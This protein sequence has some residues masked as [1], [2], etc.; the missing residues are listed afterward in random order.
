MARTRSSVFVCL[1]LL[2]GFSVPPVQADEIILN[3]GDRIHGTIVKMAD[4]LLTVTTPYADELKLNWKDVR[5]IVADRP[6]QVELN[7]ED[8]PITLSDFFFLEPP[9]VP[10][11]R[12]GEGSEIP[13]ASVRS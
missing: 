2:A 8:E 5:A 10:T 12:V 4:D 1:I 13:I 6:M 9:A 3:N 11:I 7:P